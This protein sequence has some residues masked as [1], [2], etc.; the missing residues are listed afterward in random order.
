MNRPLISIV[1]VCYDSEKTI[2]RTIKS[3]LEQDFE[4]YEYIVVDGA[5]TDSTINIIRSF[6]DRFEGRLKFKSEPDKGIYDAFSKGVKCSNGDFIWIVNSDDYLEPCSL[7]IVAAECRNYLGK[8]VILYGGLRFHKDNG[9]TLI[10]NAPSQEQI[11]KS[12]RNLLIGIPHPA[13]IYSR[14]VYDTIGLYDP[15]YYISGDAESFLLAYKSGTKFIPI[16]EI[17]SNMSDGG[18]SS[19][20]NWSKRN[21][22]FKLR[23]S[24]LYSNKFIAFYKYVK[25]VTFVYLSQLLMKR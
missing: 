1:T 12:A 7:E 8:N 22:D 21:H 23:C 2:G 17:L 25:L 13:S 19:S 10:E 3:V 4:D 6:E 24:R 20:Y 14:V 15:R 9:V 18:A 16:K 5:S 11:D